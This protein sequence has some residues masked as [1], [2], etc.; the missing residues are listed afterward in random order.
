MKKTKFFIAVR[1]NGIECAKQVDGYFDYIDRLPVGIHK[2]G[3]SWIVTEL[4]TGFAITAGPTRKAAAEKAAEIVNK[5]NGKFF[6][7]LDEKILEKYR[8][9]IKRAYA[10]M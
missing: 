2:R 8:D 9:M 10:A 4:S 5:V 7:K 1:D 6:E 3:Q